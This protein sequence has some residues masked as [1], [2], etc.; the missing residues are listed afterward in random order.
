MA[1]LACGSVGTPIAP[2]PAEDAGARRRIVVLGDSL[3]VSPSRAGGFPAL[4]QD[5][6]QSTYPGW[7]VIN[8]GV[9]GDTTEGGLQR[10]DR[11]LTADT[12][13]LVLALG[14]NDGLRHVPIATIEENLSRII[15]R[16][17]ARGLSVLLCGMETPPLNG[18]NYTLEY[19]RLFPRVAARYEVPLVPF[20]LEGVALNPEL[21]GADGL[22][23]NAAGAR[24]IAGTVWR[25]LEPLVASAR[26]QR[27][28]VQVIRSARRNDVRDSHRDRRPPT[29]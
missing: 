15:E 28:A 8:E 22:H 19:H 11:T 23:P 10:L 21:N 24:A 18:W 4:L 17:R 20:L 25:Y 9:G 5:R 14:A 13:I 26:A 12:A 16:T 29:A 2:S 7:V 3:A 27:T 1:T 6:L